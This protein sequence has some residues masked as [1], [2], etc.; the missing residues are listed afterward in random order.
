MQFWFFPFRTISAPLAE[1]NWQSYLVNFLGPTEL[2]NYMFPEPKIE[3]VYQAWKPID[4]GHPLMDVTIHYAPPELERVHI[5]NGP[6]P[7]RPSHNNKHNIVF[8][9]AREVADRHTDEKLQAEVYNSPRFD[10]GKVVFDCQNSPSDLT[11]AIS[12]QKMLMSSH[13]PLCKQLPC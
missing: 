8:E 11:V 3:N 2:G 10:K 4:Y 7:A 6:V 13:M 12:T 9:A 1:N 5:G